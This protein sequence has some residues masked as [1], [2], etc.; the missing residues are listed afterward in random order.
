MVTQLQETSNE[1]YLTEENL[2][3]REENKTKYCII[4]SLMENQN[5][6]LKRI[7]SNDRKKPSEMTDVTCEFQSE[8]TPYSCLNLKERLARNKCNI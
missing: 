2:H 7:T 6:L 4:Q 5:N 1:K 8:S 3:L